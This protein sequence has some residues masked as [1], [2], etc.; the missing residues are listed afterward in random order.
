MHPESKV[1]IL[2]SLNVEIGVRD[3]SAPGLP[4]YLVCVC[5]CM[6][7]CA[8]VCMFVCVYAC[9]CVCAGVCSSML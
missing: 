5:V 4:F 2:H 8:F 9:A 1:S 7:V 6:C 3:A